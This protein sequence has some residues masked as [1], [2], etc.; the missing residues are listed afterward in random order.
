M[1][2]EFHK[3]LKCNLLRVFPFYI[4]N[5]FFCSYKIKA[6]AWISFYDIVKLETMLLIFPLEENCML[7]NPILFSSVERTNP[8]HSNIGSQGTYACCLGRRA[9]SWAAWHT[10]PLRLSSFHLLY[11]ICFLNWVTCMFCFAFSG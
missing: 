3:P 6:L 9:T 1:L 7:W 10:C 11:L 4:H 5:Q 8:F 2:K